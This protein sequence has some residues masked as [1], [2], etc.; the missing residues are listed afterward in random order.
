MVCHCINRDQ[1]T[2]KSTTNKKYLYYSMK[3][4]K[5]RCGKEANDLKGKN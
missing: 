3:K 4:R 1:K 5:D 2:T